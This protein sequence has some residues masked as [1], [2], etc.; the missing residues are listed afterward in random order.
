M[1]LLRLIREALEAEE[2]WRDCPEDA[3]HDV[4]HLRLEGAMIDAESA[5]EAELN[6][7]IDA[8]IA[9]KEAAR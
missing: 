4:F 3:D 6:R 9:E 5:V 8:R 2:A 1:K 7:I